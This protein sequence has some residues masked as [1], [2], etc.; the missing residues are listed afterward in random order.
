MRRSFALLVAT[1]SAIAAMLAATALPASASVGSDDCTGNGVVW[2]GNGVGNLQNGVLTASVCKYNPTTRVV[3]V[4]I[5]Y[6]KTGGDPVTVRFGWQ[7]INNGATNVSFTDWDQGAFTQSSGQTR[8]Y[9]WTYANDLGPQ[10][11][12]TQRCAR[13]IMQDQNTLIV[14]VTKLVCNP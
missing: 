1:V 2:L 14:Y 12:A 7:R 4:H 3:K 5:E 11:D 6:Q 10:F 13:G 9:V 8:G